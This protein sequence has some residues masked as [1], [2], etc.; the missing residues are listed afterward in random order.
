MASYY[1]VILM[2]INGVFITQ[3]NN[4]KSKINY[5]FITSIYQANSD[6]YLFTA[7]EN[8]N[9]LISK[10]INNLS[11]YI[12]NMNKLSLAPDS[13]NK[14]LNSMSIDT[15]NN[16]YDPIRIK[17]ISK[18]YHDAYDIKSN[19]TNNEDKEKFIKYL[20]NN[21]N[22]SIIFDTPIEIKCSNYPIK[23]IKLSDDLSSLL[24][25]NSKNIVIYLNY[26]ELFLSK[27]K[28]K[29]KKNMI[30]CEKCQNIINSFKTLCQI[31]GKKL[32]PIC[33]TEIIIAECSLKYPKPICDDCLHVRYTRMSHTR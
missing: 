1:K 28:N 18:M 27:K 22:F 30:Y 12:F 33:R 23:F 9:L 3:M 25:I 19:L 5:C 13:Q 10:L 20:E 32:C 21:N 2:S 4:I 11:G 7:H 26:E 31:C 17:N 16:K 15:L 8:G 14:L 6:L 24:C 29:D